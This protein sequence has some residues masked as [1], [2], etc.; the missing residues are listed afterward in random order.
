MAAQG[1][2]EGSAAT[3][4]SVRVDWFRLEP[5]GTTIFVKPADDHGVAPQLAGEHVTGAENRQ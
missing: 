5:G 3:K 2:V 4:H 1:V